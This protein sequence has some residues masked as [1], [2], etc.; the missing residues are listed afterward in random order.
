M[1]RLAILA[2]FGL[3]VASCSSESTA[4][5]S[6]PSDTRT[7]DAGTGDA[8]N[9]DRDVLADSMASGDTADSDTA[10]TVASTH[11]VDPDHLC[12]AAGIST[13]DGIRLT[14]CLGP[15]E[16]SG[17]TASGGDVRLESGALQIVS[18]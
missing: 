1:H 11:P 5:R 10:D 8:G 16:T 3:V 9:S 18:P 13:G 2:L 4:D 15:V 7:K 17:P 14:H 6:L 12:S